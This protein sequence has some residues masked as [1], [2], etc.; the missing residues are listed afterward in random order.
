MP[1]K[2]QKKSMKLDIENI[3][4]KLTINFWIKSQNIIYFLFLVIFL[5]VHILVCVFEFS[6]LFFSRT[7]R[8]FNVQLNVLKLSKLISGSADICNIYNQR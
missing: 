1:C 3:L 8:F 4:N 2:M 7:C 5:G 6:K